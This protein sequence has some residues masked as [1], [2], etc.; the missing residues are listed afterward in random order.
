MR[1]LKIV[2]VAVGLI[3]FSGVFFSGSRPRPVGP[4]P[5]PQLTV[6]VPPTAPRVEPS[7]TPPTPP[8]T[9]PAP[10]SVKKESTHKA[11]TPQRVATSKRHISITSKR[12]SE[13]L[14]CVCTDEKGRKTHV[15]LNPPSTPPAKKGFF[16][17]VGGGMK[18]V[19][20]GIA[21]PFK[22]IGHL[23]HKKHE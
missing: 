5:G 8:V 3:L 6:V 14:F 10:E 19:G 7:P 13:P 21:K 1:M 4:P 12:P 15:V 20:S 23:F 18:K 11:T 2:A 9:H 22:A 16:K 17:K